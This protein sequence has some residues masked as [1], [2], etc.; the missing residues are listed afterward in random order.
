MTTPGSTYPN[1]CCTPPSWNDIPDRPDL[2]ALDAY[3]HAVFSAV[4]EEAGVGL[5]PQ[6]V[7]GGI[8]FKN[9]AKARLDRLDS[10]EDIAYVEFNVVPRDMTDNTNL[11][12][13]ILKELKF[14][15]KG[16]AFLVTDKDSTGK[17]YYG[18]SSVSDIDDDTVYVELALS[19]RAHV[20]SAPAIDHPIVTTFDPSNSIHSPTE[21]GEKN[22]PHTVKMSMLYSN[23]AVDYDNDGNPIDQV[24]PGQVSFVRG[25]NHLIQHPD[26][27]AVGDE[28]RISTAGAVF[29]QDTQSPATKLDAVSDIPFMEDRRKNGGAFRVLFS[30]RGQQSFMWLQ[31]SQTP[32]V[33]LGSN[34]TKA[35]SMII[36]EIYDP[37]SITMSNISTNIVMGDDAHFLS[38]IV[39]A[40]SKLVYKTELAPALEKLRREEF[41]SDPRTTSYTGWSNIDASLGEGFTGAD[42]QALLTEGGGDPPPT[43]FWI[44]FKDSSGVSKKEE[45]SRESGDEF[46]IK[47][48]QNEDYVFGTVESQQTTSANDVA[49]GW[50][51][52]Y[53]IDS[54]R[55]L[56]TWDAFPSGAIQIY[57]RG[58]LKNEYAR[59]DGSNVTPQFKAAVQ[60]ANEDEAL[61]KFIRVAVGLA[62]TADD[63]YQYTAS[64]NTMQLSVANDLDTA[65]SNDYKLHQAIK[66]RAWIR[67]ADHWEGEIVSLISRYLSNNRA[68]YYITVKTIS[69]AVPAIGQEDSV[70]IVGED[71]HRGQ[72]SQVG[73]RDNVSDVPAAAGTYKLQAVRASGGGLTF[74]WVD[75]S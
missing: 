41:I 17:I 32:T 14:L 16:G 63:R 70:T 75:D 7:Q 53:K 24:S 39:D 44:T 36:Q 28:M 26:R 38:S 22:P 42:G 25:G 52:T 61:S 46:L 35:Y 1:P 71:V 64:A 62:S 65:G 5:T 27:V 3:K 50:G 11:A 20:G 58:A 13:S 2:D 47:S 21:I 12:P 68:Q 8:R 31:I 67:I 72:I 29:G 57:I 40:Q 48:T 37:D 69:G 54:E 55:G 4:Y 51:W 45:L 6:Y 66:E 73:F 18:I 34:G 59:L 60:G 15:E 30:F 19:Y 74:S 49:V 56:D 43:Y 10:P 9:A 33:I 23:I